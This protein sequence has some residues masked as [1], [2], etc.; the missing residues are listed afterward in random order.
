MCIDVFSK[1]SSIVFL[2][3]KKV[4]ELQMNFKKF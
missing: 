3:D 2:K 1:C 4:P